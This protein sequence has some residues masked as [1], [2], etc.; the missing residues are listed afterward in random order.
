[1]IDNFLIIFQQIII[2]FVLVVAGFCCGKAKLINEQGIKTLTNVVLYLA[3]PCVIIT[4]YIREFSAPLLGDLL[5]SLAMS[6]LVHIVAIIIAKIV[7]PTK[8]RTDKSAVMHYAVVFSNAGYMGLPLQKAILGDA[9]VFF[10][11]SY[12]AVFNIMC[13][14]YGLWCMSKQS[15]SFSAKRL[16]NPGVVSVIIGIII[17]VCSIPVHPS[18]KDALTHLGN[19]NTPL[20]ML[21]IGYYLSKANLIDALKNKGVYVVSILRLVLVPLCALG[22]MYL[23]GIRG[24]MLVSMV[25]AASA[26]VATATSMFTLLCGRDE[27]TSV[28]LVSVTTVLSLVTMSVI[29]ALTQTIA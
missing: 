25:I 20:P 4:S 2:L 24:T 21:I 7:F 5:I 6:F 22:V 18:I 26:P 14:T 1:M 16:I 17:F 12:V 29:V 28:N 19:L 8:N 13:W 9:G 23:I 11:A 3:T 15:G 10:G 27:Q